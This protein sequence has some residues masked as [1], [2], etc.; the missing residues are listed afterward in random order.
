MSRSKILMLTGLASILGVGSGLLL[1]RYWDPDQDPLAFLDRFQQGFQSQPRV[2]EFTLPGLDG[3]PVSSRLWAGKVL[4]LNFWATWCGPCRQE[5]PLF[6]QIQR[7]LG[8]R[9]VQFVGI[10]IDDP[11]AVEQFSTKLGINYPI[12][13]GADDAIDLAKK[14]GNHL[15]GLP[16][17]AVLDRSGKLAWVHAGEI[18]REAL[19]QILH[20]LL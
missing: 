15:Q 8:G 9:G 1:Y 3:A 2:P 5:T 18:K 4:V 17:T 12:L 10:A 19:E 20:P 16:F 11:V 13:V 7:E 6:I 14:L